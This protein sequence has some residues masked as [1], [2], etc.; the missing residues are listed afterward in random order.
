MLD[1]AVDLIDHLQNHVE[2]LV[3]SLRG[4]I[5][6]LAVS[7]KVERTCT[8]ASTHPSKIAAGIEFLRGGTAVHPE[9]D[10]GGLG[11]FPRGMHHKRRG[12][13]ITK[14]HPAGIGTERR[15]QLL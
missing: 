1:D 7:W 9:H 14:P 10:R 12:V 8:D 13:G 6:S 4:S 15:G 11:R 2:R 3:R 5:E